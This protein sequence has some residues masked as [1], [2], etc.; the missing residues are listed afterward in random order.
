MNGCPT[1]GHCPTCGRYVGPYYNQSPYI[2]WN[3]NQP[4][5]LGGGSLSFQ[6]WWENQDTSAPTITYTSNVKTD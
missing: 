1:C 6:D 4:V 5:T 2:T 3:V